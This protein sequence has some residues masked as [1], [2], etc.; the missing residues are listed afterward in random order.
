LAD[1]GSATINAIEIRGGTFRLE[2]LSGAGIGSGSSENGG[3]SI[4]GELLIERG[5]FTVVT[6]CGGAAVGSAVGNDGRSAVDSLEIRG[7]SFDLASYGAAGIGTGT[8]DLDGMSIV[9]G[10]LI[11]GGFFDIVAIGG[12]G[13]GTGAWREASPGVSG[14]LTLYIAGGEFHVMALFGAAIGAGNGGAS[15]TPVNSLTISSGRF[16]L[17]GETEIGAGA[18]DGPVD[19]LSLAPPGA[20]ATFM[21]IG[22]HGVVTMDCF[23]ARQCFVDDQVNARVGVLRASTTAQTFTSRS[24]D[25]GIDF[26]GMYRDTSEAEPFENGT[27]LHI[28]GFESGR[29]ANVTI[30]GGNYSRIVAFDTADMKGVIVSLP[31]PGAY[32]LRGEG[33]E[34][35]GEAGAKAFT[36]NEGENYFQWAYR[37]N[38]PSTAP[39][40][41]TPLQVLVIV[42]ASGTG[43]LAIVIVVVCCVY[44]RFKPPPPMIGSY[45]DSLRKEQTLSYTRGTREDDDEE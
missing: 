34:L 35:C 40:S 41:V 11:S 19:E 10:L 45:L 20:R 21:S 28:A 18:G 27:Y 38:P 32:R 17:R 22:G 30:T 12:A 29:F 31:A 16:F 26:V 4:V 42:A 43:L 6:W 24:W 23:T 39:G 14:I 37:C 2:S 13:I 1:E 15:Y 25:P 5:N 9:S 36:V 7:G 44:K 3:W 33:A 8:A